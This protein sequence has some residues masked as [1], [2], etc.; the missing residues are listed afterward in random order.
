[1]TSRK[2]SDFETF[3]NYSNQN[4]YNLG[5]IAWLWMNSDL[6]NAWSTRLL[7]RNVIPPITLGQ[8]ELITENGFPVAYAS[9]AFFS[10]DSELRYLLKPSQITLNDWNSGDRLWFIDYISPFSVHHTMR[11]KNI[12]RSK[13]SD[14]FA[15]ALRVKAGSN[16]GRVPTYFGKNAPEDWRKNAD[17]QILSHF[18]VMD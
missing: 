11:L 4:F 8:Y 13:F 16:A 6:H 2:K 10:A 5:Q 1:M 12:L 9:W 17:F 14:Q 3:S 7:M 18:G 15:R